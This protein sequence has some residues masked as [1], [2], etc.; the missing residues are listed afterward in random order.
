MGRTVYSTGESGSKRRTRSFARIGI[1]F[2]MLLL[3][4]LPAEASAAA[5]IS[6][7][8]KTVLKGQTFTLRMKGTSKKVKWSSSKR[9]VAKVNSAGVVV[10]KKAG[11]A[12]ITA[13]VGKRRYSCNVTVRQPV[14]SVKLNKTS[15]SVRKGKS[16]KLKVK[17]KPGSAY[18]KK[19]VWKSSNS[20]IAA[21]SSSGKVTAK[22]SGSVTIT[23]STK[24]GS[25]LSASCVVLVEDPQK[26]LKLSK[27]SMELRT[28]ESKTLK[29]SGAKSPIIWSSSD[30]SVASVDDGGTVTAVGAGKAKIMAMIG[31]G[32]WIAYCDVTVLDAGPGPSAEALRFLNIIAGYSREIETQKAKGHF[33]GYSNSSTLVKSTWKEVL[34]DIVTRGMGYTNCAHTICLALRD[35]GK[36]GTNQSFWGDNGKI[37]FGSGVQATLEQSCEILHVEKTVDQL[38]AE[39][40]L[41]PGD[42]IIWRGIGH[43]NIYAGKDALGQAVWCDT[44]RSTSDGSYMA[45][46]ALKTAGVSNQTLKEDVKNDHDFPD[47]SKEIYI[48]NS[49]NPKG[50]NLGSVSIAYIIRIVR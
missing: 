20:K 43:T 44:G 11:K 45:I 6:K 26:P 27:E 13:K 41:Y 37:H 48:F 14:T 15:V 28:G 25:K 24:D 23:A 10:A 7:K 36:L 2:V 49:L 5:R 16:T 35:M 21:V 4:L 12:V 30:F 8:N 46:S 39:D 47:L 22:K 42:I 32:L 40:G 34:N 9:S 38:M 50:I 3:L 19:I 29:V 17:V 1:L 33:L 31:D 18:N